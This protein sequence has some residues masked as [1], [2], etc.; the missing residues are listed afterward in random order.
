MDYKQFIVGMILSMSKH[1]KKEE[2]YTLSIRELVYIKDRL[3][4]KVNGYLKVN[5]K[6][7]IN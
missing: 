7:Y 2:L 4:E 6:K 5:N 1:H 3:L